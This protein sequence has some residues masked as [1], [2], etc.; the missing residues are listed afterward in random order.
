M[1]KY[2]DEHDDEPWWVKYQDMTVA[3]VQAIMRPEV[4]SSSGMRCPCC[5]QYAKVYSRTITGQMVRGLFQIFH[6]RNRNLREDPRN[7]WVYVPDVLDYRSLDTVKAQYWKLL[8]PEMT[9]RNDGGRSGYWRITS[10]GLAYLFDHVA[11]PKYARI[12]NGECLELVGPPVTVMTALGTKFNY[13]ELMSTV[14]DPGD[15]S[16]SVF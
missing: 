9:I 1:T 5:R 15:N 2:D 13:D 10:L 14:T 8:Q 3:E 12:Y 6:Q 16:S 7:E 11:V 4:S